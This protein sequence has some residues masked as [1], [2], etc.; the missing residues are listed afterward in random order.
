MVATVGLIKYTVELNM[1]NQLLKLH[2]TLFLAHMLKLRLQNMVF[3]VF[4]HIIIPSEFTSL[5]LEPAYRASIYL[6]YT[7]SAVDL[8]ALFTDHCFAPT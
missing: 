4:C 7:Y 5:F 3:A 8:V 1:L 2:L 6:F